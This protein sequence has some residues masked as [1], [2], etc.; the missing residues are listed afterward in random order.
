M[1]FEKDDRLLTK[2][3][4]STFTNQNQTAKIIFPSYPLS[5]LIKIMTASALIIGSSGRM[6]RALLAAG[7]NTDLDFH[8]FTR[9]KANISKESL[10]FCASVIEGDALNKSDIQRALIQSSADY[11]VVSVG[12]GDDTSRTTIRTDTAKVISSAIA[13][14]S[15]F[16]YV[17]VVVVSSTGAGHSRIKPGMGLGKMITYM[18]RYVIEDHNGQEAAFWQLEKSLTPERAVLSN[19]INGKRIELKRTLIVRPVSLTEGKATGTYVTF[20]GRKKTPKLNVDR[21]DI[22]L[23]ITKRIEEDAHGGAKAIPLGGIVHLTSE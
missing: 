4:T 19:T 2:T 5:K 11:V 10:T 6:G 3:S 14:D 18:L 21:A 15:R 1:L 17:K 23:Y 8:A 7:Q 12:K 16:H 22:A 9:S 20:D 13:A